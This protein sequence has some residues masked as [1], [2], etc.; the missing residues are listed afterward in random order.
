MLKKIS[1]IML[2]LSLVGCASHHKMSYD[3]SGVMLKKYAEGEHRSK[4]NK[5]RNVYRNPVETLTFFELKKDMHV[6]EISPGGGWYSE[7]LGPFLKDKGQ[8]T[9]TTFD[10]NSD[11]GYRVRLNKTLREKVQPNSELY[12]DVKFKTFD[13]PDAV[14]PLAEN[15]SVD[16]VLTFRNTHS[17]M[18]AGSFK[19]AYLEFLRV[20]KPG[21]ILGV[22]QHRA[23]P[24]V[25]VDP[26]KSGYVDEAYLIKALEDLGFE[27]VAKS[28]VN[29]NELDTHDHPEGVWTLPPSL[30]LKDKNRSKYLA[31]GESDRMTLKFRKPKK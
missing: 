19:K 6:L 18:R 23:R 24:G 27:F 22:V 20:L 7:I 14:E 13:L 16:R 8:L 2:V 5:Q 9:L 4:K 21:G 15:D 29:A 30:R 31:I 1:F 11:V 3:H 25:N 17:F 12:G 26:K 28:E 10:D